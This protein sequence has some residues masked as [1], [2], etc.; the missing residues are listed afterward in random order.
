VTG[1]KPAIGGRVV[2]K[3]TALVCVQDQA[4]DLSEC[5]RRLW[6]CDEIVVV[7]DRCRDDSV[8]IARRH[9][10]EVVSGSFPLESQRRAAGLQAAGGDW[11]LE[12]A[13]DERV[14]SP[15]AWEIRATLKTGLDADSFEVPIVN[16]VGKDRTRGAWAADVRADLEVRL[17]RPGA[18]RWAEARSDPG[19]A[20][21]RSA[22]ALTGELRRILGSGV[23][24]VL[25]RFDRRTELA[26][27][28]LVEDDVPLGLGRAARSG[29]RAAFR[30]YVSRSGW[31]E[32]GLGLALAALAGLF[33][34]IAQLKAQ[35]LL[36]SR[37]EQAAEP[38]KSAPVVRLG[39]G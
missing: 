23:S 26:A 8:E 7:A 13:P 2:V 35:E 31:R 24:D 30:S 36:R 39:V 22:G 38:R 12:I 15:L 20:V 25:E 1:S 10:A 9:G 32:G 14:D 16:Y 11:I 17:Y 3:L 27:E 21:G 19:E 29:A 5:L 33:P 34:L 37:A 18:K 6:F 28:A 4:D